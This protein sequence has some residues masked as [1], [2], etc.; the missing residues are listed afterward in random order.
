MAGYARTANRA[1]DR[2]LKAG[3]HPTLRAAMRWIPDAGGK[4]LRPVLAQM[5][6]E[7]VG[8]PRGAR[9]ALPVGVALEVIHNFTLVHDDIMDRS[10]LRRN[11]A[12][13]HVK[14]DA[15][16]AINAG[17]ALFARAFEIM[18]DIPGRDALLVELYGEV[19]SMVRGIAEGQ[20]WDMQF[21]KAKRVSRAQYLLMVERKTALMF[22]T[23]S[24]CG[25]RSAGAAKRLAR[26]LEEYG[27]SLGIAFQIQ[28]DLLDLGALERDLGKPIG[29]DIRNGK[30]TVMVIDAL[31]ALKGDRLREFREILGTANASKAMVARAVELMDGCGSLARAR[32]LADGYGDAARGSLRWVRK[33]PA[34]DRLEALIS[35]VTSRAK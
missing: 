31:A 16:T 2:Y 14:W 20:Q 22:S 30:R 3:D 18:Q 10:D 8:G 24:Y 4:R 11:R 29:K 17:D 15:S 28:D 12:T 25:A 27:R 34:R 32:A 35:Y 33:G 6:G 9:A 1:L 7:A 21:E 19:A 13:V 23:G 26:E 5:V